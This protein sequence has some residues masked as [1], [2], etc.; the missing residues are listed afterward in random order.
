MFGEA[1]RFQVDMCMELVMA[2]LLCQ[3]CQTLDRH[4]YTSSCVLEDFREKFNRREK[5]HPGYGL[6]PVSWDAGL[7][8]KEKLS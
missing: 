6:Q 2:N 7:N 3:F 4:G 5:A 8:G 1:F